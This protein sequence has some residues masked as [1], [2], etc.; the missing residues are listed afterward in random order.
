MTRK[1]TY[2]KSL[3]REKFE[4]EGRPEG[5]T[6]PHYGLLEESISD[7]RRNT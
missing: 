6:F 2:K 7:G 1:A 3:H 5:C 4:A